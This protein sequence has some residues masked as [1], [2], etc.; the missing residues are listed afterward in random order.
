MNIFKTPY[1][2]GNTLFVDS[3]SLINSLPLEDQLFLKQCVVKED[4]IAVTY[5]E[6]YKLFD[7]NLDFIYPILSPHWLTG[8]SVLRMIFLITESDSE[9]LYEVNG[10]K[11]TQQD[12]NRLNAIKNFI[13][14][15]VQNNLNIRLIHQWQEGDLIIPDLHRMI[16]TVQGGFN[17][18]D[19][20]FRGL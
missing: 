12:N 6:A 4:P 15:E 14:H 7:H 17:P 2:H 11:P 1:D 5:K 19:R 8:E 20:K 3:I 10:R 9:T 18:E 16:H 13:V